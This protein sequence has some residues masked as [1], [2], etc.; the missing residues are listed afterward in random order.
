MAVSKQDDSA[1]KLFE[2]LDFEQRREVVLVSP[3][4]IMA[5]FMLAMNMIPDKGFRHYQALLGLASDHVQLGCC[6]NQRPRKSAQ[7]A[8]QDS[9]PESPA[10]SIPMPE[11]S[12]SKKRVKTQSNSKRNVRAYCV[13]LLTAALASLPDVLKKNPNLSLME[14]DADDGS[15]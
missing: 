4:C 9:L 5:N 2:P 1:L 7:G 8:C 13:H 12:P 15:K 11:P 3:R 10:S 14:A 6:Y